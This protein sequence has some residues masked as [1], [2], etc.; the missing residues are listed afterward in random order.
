[1]LGETVLLESTLGRPRE[2]GAPE[3]PYTVLKSSVVLP[4]SARPASTPSTEAT[5]LTAC[6]TISLLSTGSKEFFQSSPVASL[7][8]LILLLIII[9]GDVS[10]GLSLIKV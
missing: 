6:P 9:S 3:A 8:L 10:A 7:L 1:M 4:A 2:P 5:P